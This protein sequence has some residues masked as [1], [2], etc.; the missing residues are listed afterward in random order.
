MPFGI[1]DALIWGPMIGAAVGGLTNK[2]D[3][4]KGAALGGL[5]G[6]AGGTFLAPGSAVAGAVGNPATAA[7]YG[8]G[9]GSEQTAMLAAQDAG[10]AE[11][12]LGTTPKTALAGLKDVGAAASA[13]NSVSGLLSPRQPQIQASPVMQGGAG[14]NALAQ[15]ANSAQQVQQQAYQDELTKRAQ[16]RA[17]WG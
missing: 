3:P 2:K 6:Y 9:L 16:R 1:D 10:M 14:S 4:L 12:L 15:L 7:A 17:M 5:A 8:T 13:A 11:G